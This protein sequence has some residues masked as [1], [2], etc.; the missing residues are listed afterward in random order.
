[1]HHPSSS[2]FTGG[3]DGTI[4]YWTMTP[5]GGNCDSTVR[6]IDTRIRCSEKGKSFCCLFDFL[7]S[8]NDLFKNILLK[9]SF[10][11]LL[12]LSFIFVIDV[13]SFKSC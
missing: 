8:S 7:L 10:L 2:C 13:S 6:T 9:I 5:T 1:M 4:R 3:A 12:C 11:S